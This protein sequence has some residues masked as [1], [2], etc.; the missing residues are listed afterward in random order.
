MLRN[1]SLRRARK[2]LERGAAQL[3]LGDAAGAASGY[4]EALARIGDGERAGTQ[5]AADVAAEA[6]I[7]RGRAHLLAGGFHEALDCFLRAQVA[8]PEWWEPHHR[9]GC[10]AAHLANW[11]QAVTCWTTALQCGGPEPDGWGDGVTPA[12]VRVQRAYAHERQGHTDEAR[13]DLWAAAAEG[14]LEEG[15]RWTL[16]VLELRAGAWESA[17]RVLRQ[18]MD[19]ASPRA[20]QAMAMLAHAMERQGQAEKA[21]ASYQQAIDGG[22]TED[23]VLFRH[24]FVA[25]GLGRYDDAVTSWTRLHARHPH[26]ARLR[27][28]VARATLAAAHP[29]VVR[30]D[31]GAALDRLARSEP[32]WPEGPPEG[33][34]G[35]VTELH[36]YAAW[37]AAA[38]HDEAGRK[39]ARW[40]LGE[41]Y[42]RRPDDHRVQRH[43][44]P[45]AFLAGE[46]ER[47]VSLWESALR[48]VPG[49]PEVRYAL[50]VCRATDVQPPGSPP[51]P[52]LPGA[53]PDDQPPGLPDE[54]RSGAEP[55][56]SMRELE[57]LSAEATVPGP[58]APV[59]RGGTARRAACALAALYI[60]AGQWA[61]AVH[62]LEPLTPGPRRDAL[63]AESLYRSGRAHY[64]T[65][66][67]LSSDL[68][69]WW[70]AVALCAEGRLDLVRK[71]VRHAPPRGAERA[72]RELALLLREKALSAVTR[73]LELERAGK[74]E[75]IGEPGPEREPAAGEEGWREAASLFALARATRNPAAY[76]QR[77]AV[78]DASVLLRGGKYAEAVTDLAE[79]CGRDP[80]DHRAAHTLGLALLHGLSARTPAG[81]ADRADRAGWERCLAVWATVLH[82]DTFWADFQSRAERRYGTPVQS[83]HMEPLRGAFRQLLENRLPH[84][85]GEAGGDANGSGL[86][87][88]AANEGHAQAGGSLRLLFQREAEAAQA[89]KEF[90][91]FPGPRIPQSSPVSG[92][93]P[94][95]GPRDRPGSGTGS[96]TGASARSGAGARRGSGATSQHTSTLVCG[97]LRL[98]QL[99]LHQEFGAFLAERVAAGRASG[100]AGLGL[101]ER[102][103][104]HGSGA[105][106]PGGEAPLPD[107]QALA[108]LVGPAA[109]RRVP[110]ELRQ[111]FSQ[112]GPARVQFTAGQLKEALEALADLRCP[113]CRARGGQRAGQHGGQREGRHGDPGGPLLCAQD[114]PDF[115]VHNPGY[116][117]LQAKHAALAG[118]AR[119][120]A[121]EA[122]LGLGLNALTSGEPDLTAA[123]DHWREAAARGADDTQHSM[124]EMAIGRAGALTRARKLD[125]AVDVLALAHGLL[126]GAER[127]RV[128]GRLASAL[129]DR[130]VVSANNDIEQLEQ[131][132]A[133]L[134][135]AADLNPHLLRAQIN[136]G[137]VLRAQGVQRARE[138]RVSESL[139]LL[140][141]TVDRMTAALRHN[142]SHRELEDI[143]GK[144]TADL[145]V[146]LSRYGR[147]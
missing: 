18:L 60:R 9:A 57:L 59:V 133:D 114:C 62:V 74:P 147:R 66:D 92:P 102:L 19:P 108:D 135:R 16:A 93:A 132:T 97:P 26:R 41:A 119:D 28:L 134:R 94:V 17:E 37:R 68:G 4:D 142:G 44:A 25:Y 56:A 10:A 63:L 71:A 131:P 35:T 65:G 43:L 40:H 91:G 89:L 103:R 113:A 53:P 32:L 77:A 3:A 129:T 138:G 123:R 80:G 112:L 110:A 7:G 106:L 67:R 30:K 116:A 86:G 126:T 144:T 96:R 15:A 14:P 115:D 48:Q 45:L 2:A 111:L 22:N 78:L 104:Q 121:A 76:P 21:L 12:G 20:P 95:P 118:A 124:A 109:G 24:G 47:A 73:A 79:A 50:A 82:S 90:G 145:S 51:D 88:V 75:P 8:R 141:E 81:E 55:L 105:R 39:E 117:D 69:P 120:L 58:G 139:E 49:D 136:L 36:L 130:G 46:R 23:A 128:R 137:L 143:L 140:Q 52:Q 127:E 85:N 13:A 64:V 29:H 98:A 125:E 70:R 54:A 1:L 122:L 83:A 31:F 33:F 11:G 27:L 61:E 101:F 6:L 146:L 84:A 72:A 42:A 34:A 100:G 5:E 107:L 87:A 38:R 99:G